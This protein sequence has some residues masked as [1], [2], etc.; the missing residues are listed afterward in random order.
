MITALEAKQKSSK[1]DLK[2]IN[3]L[4]E[5][6]AKKGFFFITI[7]D[8]SW[9]QKKLLYEL[10]YDVVPCVGGYLISWD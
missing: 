3:E 10:K 4:I 8:L 6:A 7:Y 1:I 5:D 9:S 2:Y